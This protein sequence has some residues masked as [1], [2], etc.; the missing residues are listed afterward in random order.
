M[1]CEICFGNPEVDWVKKSKNLKWIQLESV[2]FEKY[3][4]IKIPGLKISNL[5]GFFSIP[6]AETALAGILSLKEE[7]TGCL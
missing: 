5:R 4:K 6:V 3:T 1:N 7:F 2:G